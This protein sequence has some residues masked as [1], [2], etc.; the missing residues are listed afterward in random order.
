MK[1]PGRGACMPVERPTPGRLPLDELVVMP[2]EGFPLQIA[3]A[4]V[5]ELAARGIAARVDAAVPLPH[6]AY[7]PARGQYRAESLLALV[8]GHGARHVLAITE[9]D[10]FAHDLNFV[11][12]IASPAGAC[13]VSTARLVAGADDALFGVRLVKEALH[14]L[15]HTLGLPHCA[16]PGCVMYFSNSLPDTD[17]KG[18]AYCERCATRLRARRR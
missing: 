4:L 13:V 10:L 17:R 2:F 6:T 14:E 16:D 3:Q 15:G 7:V 1:D 9:R 11:F 8:S 5:A 12:G 18:D